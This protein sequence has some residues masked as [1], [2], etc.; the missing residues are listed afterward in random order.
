MKTI[1]DALKSAAV[2]LLGTSPMA[3]FGNDDVTGSE[4]AVLAQEALDDL[5]QVRDWSA[6]ARAGSATGDGSSVLFDLPND[7]GRLPQNARCYLTGGN[8]G[9]PILLDYAESIQSPLDIAV[10]PGYYSY[11]VWGLYGN[12]LGVAPIIA[13]GQSVKYTYISNAAVISVGAAVDSFKSDTDTC[14]LP[15]RLVSL[16]VIWR[17]RSLKGMD[18]AEAMRTYELA[19]ARAIANDKG[20]QT[21]PLDTQRWGG[22]AVGMP[23]PGVLG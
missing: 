5:V 14:L 13:V 1:G 17:W 20:R 4:L 22:L 19:L 12:Q 3:F 21:I 8:V 7:F 10:N 6:L 18:Y 9:S 11:P 15:I 23:Y 2:Q 16:S